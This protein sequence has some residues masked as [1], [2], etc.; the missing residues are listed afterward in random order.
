M[1]GIDS[2]VLRVTERFCHAFQR[3]TGRTN[4]WL[5]VQLTNL[6][7]VVYFVWAG[8]YSW[9][10]GLRERTLFVLFCG[11]LLW[12]LMQTVFTVPIEASENAAFERVAR[13]L[14]NPRRIRDA[15]LR[16]SFLTLSVFLVYPV[17]FAYFSRLR[18]QVVLLSYALVLLTT[19]VL[20]LLACDPLPPCAGKLR[21]WL[22]GAARARPPA[23]EAKVP[24]RERS[25]AEHQAARAVGP[26]LRQLG[27]Q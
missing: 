26:R 14:R 23:T 6:S 22:R 9:S 15:S 7:I 8:L 18:L 20:Y 10:L 12:V 16:I 4:V 13:G 24:V 25:R 11:G 19:A 17:F 3:L 5:A 2:I 1:G 27:R 21:E